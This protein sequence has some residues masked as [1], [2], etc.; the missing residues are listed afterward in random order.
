LLASGSGKT[1]LV[2]QYAD[3]HFSTQHKSTIGCDYITKEIR[4]FGY[5]VQL[6]IWVLRELN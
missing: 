5:H 1:S 3:K 2:M 6:Q 4:A